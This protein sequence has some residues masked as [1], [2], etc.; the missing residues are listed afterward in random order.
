MESTPA[1]YVDLFKRYVK[2]YWRAV[3]ALAVLLFGSIALQLINP[4]IVG[5]FIDATTGGEPA[6]VLLSTALLFVGLAL[7]QQIAS[8]LAAYVSENLAWNTTNAMRVD[9]AD[10]CLN[11]DMSFH[12]V[13]KPGEMIERLDG[14]VS[15]LAAFFSTFVIQ[16]VGSVFLLLGALV[17]LYRA[18]WRIGASLTGF[19]V[20]TLL[21]MIRLRNIAVPHWKAQREASAAVFGFLEERLAGTEDIRACAGKSYVLR[22]FYELVRE[23]YRKMLKA[24]LM[25][26]I[27][28]NASFLVVTLGTAV[29]LAVGAY[30]FRA[31]AVSI[32]TVVIVLAYTTMLEMPIRR[33]THQMEYLQ[34]AVAAI[35]RIQEL[36]HT[37]N[38][39]RQQREAG[40]VA[41]APATQAPPQ[42][43]LAVEFQNV[44]FAYHDAVPEEE[45]RG[46]TA[47]LHTVAPPPDE[48][49]QIVLHDLSFHLEQGEVLGLL[50][51]TGSGKTTLTR[52]LFRLY[53]PDEGA[54]RL[55]G[56]TSL[57][58]IR[59]L[60][61][62]HLRQ[63][64][65]LVTQDVQIFRATVRDNVTFF[66]DRVPD[67]RILEVIQ[68][69]GLGQWF[70]SLPDGLD[71]EMESGGGGLSAG[72]AQLLAF[73]RIFIRD[74]G[75]V[76][77]DEASSRLDPATEQLLERAM[78]RL[79]QGRTAI[80]IAHRLGTVQRADSILILEG[81]RTVEHGDRLELARDPDSR[82]YGLLQTGLEE[83]LA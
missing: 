70:A 30:V 76:I 22:R 62:G 57:T 13:R 49:E 75:L 36:F 23:L 25:V 37:K 40:R 28:V 81:G 83:V 14:D 68:E 17:L 26:N 16:V 20:L 66:D 5:R 31:G 45:E 7:T 59:C 29:A 35:G 19:V 2:P 63:R 60:P 55:G 82:F 39:L 11:L 67:E 74:P 53:D 34:Q 9:L 56:P 71:T 1:D 27:M 64:V 72:E 48:E 24:A 8:V 58:D 65:G 52:L 6:D 33:I 44:T 54:V 69:L 10:H 4:Q 77:L 50:G 43:A 38:R 47:S 51:R 46:S 61:L 73:A 80:I 21:V 15:I 3:T 12:N 79:I 32:G 78:A 42:G 41:E 18:D